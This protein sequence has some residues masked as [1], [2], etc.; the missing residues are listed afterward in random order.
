MVA[1]LSSMVQN[2]AV[3]SKP[4]KAPIPKKVGAWQ[5]IAGAWKITYAGNGA[6]RNYEID[7]N[8]NVS[9]DDGTGT[10][11]KTTL[12]KQGMDIIFD[13]KDGKLERFRLDGEILL[14][15]HFDPAS[16]FPDS[17]KYTGRGERQ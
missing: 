3:A 16:S 2:S 14:V 1:D 7:P 13:I 5:A 9:F 10:I 6:V 4:A 15:E 17:P 12:F 11:W 8:G